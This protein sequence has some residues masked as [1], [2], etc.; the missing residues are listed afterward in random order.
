MRN[1]TFS[2]PLGGIQYIVFE[3]GDNDLD[4]GISIPDKLIG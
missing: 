2:G 1:T 3:Q 4:T